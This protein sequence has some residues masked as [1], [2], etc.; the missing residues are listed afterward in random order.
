MKTS[1]RQPDP[2]LMRDKS[3]ALN[4]IRALSRSPTTPDRMAEAI[5]QCIQLSI[6]SLKDA[7]VFYV[8]GDLYFK[9]KAFS[10]AR[11]ALLQS[12]QL[13][14]KN[15]FTRL[16]LTRCYSD[17]GQWKEALP[18]AHVALALQSSEG[19]LRVDVHNLEAVSL[20]GKEAL[21]NGDIETATKYLAQ[22]VIRM[23]RDRI[24]SVSLWR[25]GTW[26]MSG[27]GTGSR[28]SMS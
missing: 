7:E 16:L 26:I 25:S 28:A 6:D 13:E 20:L 14:P 22:F 5:D 23:H 24:V 2:K 11:D 4:S 15:V 27:F 17:M 18:H 21:F 19:R 12:A 1:Y 10:Q 9:T 3:A 8:L